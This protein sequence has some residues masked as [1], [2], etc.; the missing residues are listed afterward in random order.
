MKQRDAASIVAFFIRRQQAGVEKAGVG[1]EPPDFVRAAAPVEEIGVKVDAPA[2]VAGIAIGR[3]RDRWIRPS[4]SR[5][6]SA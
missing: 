1:L 6:S 2:G 4:P 3:D 5:R